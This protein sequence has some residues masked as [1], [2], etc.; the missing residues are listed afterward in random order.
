MLQIINISQARNNLASMVKKVKETKE[1]LVIVQD[2]KPVVVM[3]PYE[4]ASKNGQ[5]YLNK[6]LTIKGDWFSQEEFE[7]TR[8]ETEKRLSRLNK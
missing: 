2:S 7:A 3:Y 1:P 6:L 5:D 4:Q 8:F